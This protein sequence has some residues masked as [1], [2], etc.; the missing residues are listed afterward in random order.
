MLFGQA[1]GHV[2]LN[3]LHA[4]V[5]QLVPLALKAKSAQAATP[6][7]VPDCPEPPR[8]PRPPPPPPPPPAPPLGPWPPPDEHAEAATKRTPPA[9]SADRVIDPAYHPARS[10]WAF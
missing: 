2:Q 9:A 5:N 8:P 3:A 7:L 4:G 6:P 1:P 10:L